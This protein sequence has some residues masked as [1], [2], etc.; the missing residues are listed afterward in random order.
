MPP[1][2]PNVSDRQIDSFHD[3]VNHIACGKQ[4]MRV[5]DREVRTEPLRQQSC[6]IRNIKWQPER[7]QASKSRRVDMTSG[8][9]EEI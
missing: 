6:I 1:H 9:K 5:A 4:A 8:R 7:S 3:A 2:S